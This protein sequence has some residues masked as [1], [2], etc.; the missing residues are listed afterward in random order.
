MC[1]PFQ[2]TH[3]LCCCRRMHVNTIFRYFQ[4]TVIIQIAHIH[5]FDIIVHMSHKCWHAH[6]KFRLTHKH[7]AFYIRKIK[8]SK[9][10]EGNDSKT[11]KI[12]ILWNELDSGNW[13]ESIFSKYLYIHYN[14]HITWLYYVC[15]QYHIH[16]T[17]TLNLTPIWHIFACHFI[18]ESFCISRSIVLGCQPKSFNP[19]K[20]IT[21]KNQKGWNGNEW[22]MWDQDILYKQ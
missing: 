3:I 22:R 20:H 21:G 19:W 7:D 11:W 8:A 18:F 12:N 17:N 5:S 16:T 13:S 4:I 9:L 10:G 14:L 15:S 1:L 6:L 2:L